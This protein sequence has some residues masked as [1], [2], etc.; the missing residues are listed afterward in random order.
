[1]TETINPEYALIGCV[2]AGYRQ[3]DELLA[4]V[5]PNDFD[6]PKF[7][8]IWRAISSVVTTGE[9]PEAIRVLQELGP[10]ANRLPGGPTLLADAVAAAPVVASAPFY[11]ELVRDHATRRR[12][13]S[14]A[15]EIAGK[16]ETLEDVAQLVEVAR[17]TI[18][19]ATT[20]HTASDIRLVSDYLPEVYDIAEH[21]HP[22]GL[23]T[24]WPSV[25]RIIRGLQ[26]G[27]LIVIGARPGIGKSIMGTN[28]AHHVA[29]AHGRS[30]FFASLE[31]PGVEVTQRLVA[32]HASLMLHKLDSGDMSDLSW[33]KLQAAHAEIDALP[34]FVDDSAD[35]SLASMRSFASAIRRRRDDLGLIVVDYLQ[36]MSARDDSRNR[37]EQVGEM[38]R[39]LKKLAR[40]LGVTVVAMAQV[41]RGS[42]QRQSG[43]PN[44]ADLRE[45]GSIEADAD[46]VILLHREKNEDNT[47]SEVVDVL[48]EKNRAGQVT[49]TS[50]EVWGHYSRLSEKSYSPPT[51]PYQ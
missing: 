24:P 2:L 45:S 40:E 35:Q 11:A 46:I 44:M 7:E 22:E 47:L 31:M 18:E 27:R 39:G 49:A 26:P 13:S 33:E 50:L 3:V 21:G 30:V 15:R 8:T 48:V 41:N 4:V 37:A 5:K 19:G 17:S 51:T 32:H 12:I 38:S 42:T 1:M 25:D 23:D 34:I 29:K 14:A 36:L 16:A 10:E 9:M 28:L 20:S 43:K 6:E